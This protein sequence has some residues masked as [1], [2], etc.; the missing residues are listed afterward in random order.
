MHY[1]LISGHLS[2]ALQF[3]I[4]QFIVFEYHLPGIKY[5]KYSFFY[6]LTDA[7]SS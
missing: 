5:L 3:Y 7:F 6:L 2:F 1:F 4:F